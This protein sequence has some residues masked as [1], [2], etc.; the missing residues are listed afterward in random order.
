MLV[1]GSSLAFSPLATTVMEVSKLPLTNDQVRAQSVVFGGSLVVSRSGAAPFTGG[2]AFKLFSAGTS[3]GAFAGVSLPALAQGLVWDATRLYV[4]GS[5]SIAST[6]P[7]QISGF[8]LAGTNLVLSGS[9]GTPDGTCYLRASTNITLPAAQWLRI[10]TNQFDAGGSFILTFPLDSNIPE[11]F[12][13]LQ[14][15]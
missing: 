5:V 9:G 13:R 15:P 7:P 14:V 12:Y 2:E 11:R 4:D 10:A 8:S 3:S 6:N 1:F